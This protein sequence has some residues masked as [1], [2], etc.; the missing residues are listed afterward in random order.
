MAAP[1]VATYTFVNPVIALLLGWW[2]LGERISWISLLAAALVVGSIVLLLA[3][4]QR[5]EH[6]PGSETFSRAPQHRSRLSQ[7]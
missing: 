4:P 6:V 2:L 1:I 5:G 7:F 3:F